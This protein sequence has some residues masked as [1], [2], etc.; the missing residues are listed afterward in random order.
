MTFSHPQYPLYETAPYDDDS[1][2]KTVRTALVGDTQPLEDQS[3]LDLPTTFDLPSSG[4]DGGNG[5][6]GGGGGID[7][8]D[9]TFSQRI[10]SADWHHIVTQAGGKYYMDG[11]PNDTLTY[12]LGE[13]IHFDLSSGTLNADAYNGHPFAIYTDSSKTTEITEGVEQ[14]GTDLLFTPSAVGTYS[15]QCR[16]HE[17]M[18]GDIIVS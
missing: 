15:Y 11:V 3:V 7:V 9:P 6:N 13:T 16:N 5:G 12:L 18:G 4:G 8:G 10:E 2:G 14:Q 1:K 17:N